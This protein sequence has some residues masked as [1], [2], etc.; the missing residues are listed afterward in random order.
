MGTNL[1]ICP[2]A[3]GPQR[4]R[5]RADLDACNHVIC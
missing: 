2:F 1:Q 4:N 3:L 5:E